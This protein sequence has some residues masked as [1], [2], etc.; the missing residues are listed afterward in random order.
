MIRN[1]HDWS[2]L[3]IAIMG[4]ASSAGGTQGMRIQK[5]RADEMTC[6]SDTCITDQKVYFAH[7]D[8]FNRRHPFELCAKLPKS[9]K[10]LPLDMANSVA[11]WI[12]AAYL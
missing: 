10:S 7:F 11:A 5:S 8:H 3:D 4:R 1:C 2:E 6:T 12:P 9:K